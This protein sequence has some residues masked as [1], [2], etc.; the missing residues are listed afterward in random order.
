[1][2]AQNID[3]K[4][5]SPKAVHGVIS[6]A[7]NRMQTPAE[8]ENE[9]GGDFF[10]GICARV[11][12]AYN[13]ALK[14]NN[15]M[16]FDDLLFH[17]VRL[18]QTHPEVLDRYSRRFRYIHVDEYQDTNRAQYTIVKM[19]ASHQNLCVVGD[20]DQ[21]IYAWRGA[22]L[23]NILDFE[24]DFPSCTVIRLEQNYRSTQPILEAANAV[25]AN[26]RGRKG[27][28]L[29]TDRHGGDPVVVHRSV[30][31]REEALF[32][33]DTVQ[34]LV[35]KRAYGHFA[36]LYRTNAQSRIFEEIFRQRGIPYRMVGGQK[37][38]DRAEI[39]DLVAY[40]RFLLNPSDGVSLSRIIN[41]PR[42][43]IGNVTLRKLQERSSLE[44]QSLWEGVQDADESLVG[45]RAKE[46]LGQYAQ[47]MRVL[48]AQ[49]DAL[50][51]ADF[52][53][54]V[55]E[56]TGLMAQYAREASFEAQGRME[57]LM[58]FVNAVADYFR[59]H[60]DETLTDYLSGLALVADADE[61][62]ENTDAVTLMTM[63]SAKGLEF[64]VV[65]VVGMEEGL[66]PHS[67]S[68][69][70][71]AGIEEERRLCYVG[72][73]R[74]MDRLFLSYTLS[75][76]AYGNIAHNPPSRFLSELPSD[77]CAQ[78]RSRFRA[79][80][81]LAVVFQ[82]VYSRNPRKTR[83]AP[84]VQTGVRAKARSQSGGCGDAPGIRRR[85]RSWYD[86][87]RGQHRGRDRF[88][89]AGRQAH[90]AQIRLDEEGVK[91]KRECASW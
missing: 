66:C 8:F 75:R 40:L 29:W 80:D 6:D 83:E 69:G 71:E 70:D 52:V 38:Y 41:V 90:H 48:M 27:K 15:A 25:I 55:I 79:R 42:R 34:N 73:T 21:S 1:M 65:F 24:Q 45:K 16:D 58:E 91:W 74:A 28:N 51:S 63:H 86:G 72:F 20:D 61:Y 13:A 7:K 4:K 36:V 17:T 54:C 18:F 2:R 19:L 26:N 44:G 12:R 60:P 56:Q 46:K 85:K 59:E 14:Q 5:F 30:S 88:W 3:E 68:L 22:D 43:G 77:G 82:S 31:E 57:N 81:V 35:S 67:R 37:F 49:Y 23:R 11:Y 76:G 53:R 39:R 89:S 84:G 10:Y 64:P 9:M 87:K 78:G 50:H 33:A 32:V 47:D 62:E